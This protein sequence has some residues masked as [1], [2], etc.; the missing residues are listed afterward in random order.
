MEFLG[1]F[2]VVAMK[3]PRKRVFALG[4]RFV[5]TSTPGRPRVRALGLAAARGA[6]GQLGVDD[7]L[8]GFVVE[9]R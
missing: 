7:P 8:A 6:F 9:Q 2:I 1:L 3:G 4:R 5:G